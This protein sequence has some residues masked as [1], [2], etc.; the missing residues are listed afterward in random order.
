MADLSA[1]LA[2]RA[3]TINLNAGPSP[4]PDAALLTAASSLL[5]YPDT[6]GMGVAEIS[7][8]SPAF[9]QIMDNANNDLRT[10]LDIPQNYKILWMQGGGLTQFAATVLN[11][12]AWYRI[13]HQLKPEDE[14][15]ALYAVTGS[16]SAKAAEEGARIGVNATKVVDGKKWGGGKFNGIP[17][18]EEWAIP[19]HEEN[20]RKPAFV[21][22]CDNE[23][24]DGVEFGGVGAENAFPFHKF[25]P[26]IPVV[27][28]MSSN[29]LSRPVD[30][31][32]YGII[33]AGAQKNLGPAGVTL[34]IVREDLIVD[35]DEAVPFGG[36]RVP[37]MLSYKNMASSNSMFNTPPT[38]TIYVCS[39]VLRTLLTSPPMPLE[40]S[41]PALSPLSAFADTKSSLVYAELDNPSG[42]YV[43]T[44]NKDAR[45][46]MN[47]TF[48]LK[49]GEAL[50]K[51]FV[52]EASERG[53]KG[54]N[55]HRSVGGIRASI[56][57]AVT[58]EQVKALVAFMREFRAKEESA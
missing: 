13:K 39:L 47:V 11:L 3:N 10:L 50:E 57:N 28:D 16:W 25:D 33:Y 7:H 44:A 46:R 53:I 32:K 27:A 6:P 38:F 52:K 2:Q 18:A 21:Y 34:V 26:E 37:S 22:F 56:Y 23:T 9:D 48:R 8:R 42:F 14:V 43:G 20:A 49:G 29:F 15:D 40:P 36:A 55:G 31:S 54:V 17:Q 51:K 5:S 4:L 19:Q 45:S 41:A 58:L 1:E 24:V 30:V 35:L 12:L